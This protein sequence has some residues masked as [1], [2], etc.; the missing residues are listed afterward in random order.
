MLADPQHRI[1]ARVQK[2][3]IDQSRIAKL[4]QWIDAMES[5]APPLRHFVLAG[6][7]PGAAMLHLARAVCRRAE[8]RIVALGTDAVPPVVV[9]YINRLSDLLFAMARVTNA[10]AGAHETEW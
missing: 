10:R 6:G 5:S 4:E 7:I 2:A 8:R 9:I 3:T 1:A